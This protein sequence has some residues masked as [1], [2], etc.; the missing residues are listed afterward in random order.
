MCENAERDW[1]GGKSSLFFVLV[2]CFRTFLPE[3]SK[4]T[5]F[6]D[7]NK[8]GFWWKLHGS[9]SVDEN[10]CFVHRFGV[11]QAF[12]YMPEPR[13]FNQLNKKWDKKGQKKC[14]ILNVCYTK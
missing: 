5:S 1:G 2:V 14:V 12:P 9:T 10:D 7:Q 3:R 11:V 4:N 13:Q 8:Y 6:Y